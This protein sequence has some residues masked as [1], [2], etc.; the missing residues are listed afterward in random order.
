MSVDTRREEQ[1]IRRTT[2]YLV[3]I[4]AGTHSAEQVES[5]MQA[6]HRRF[7]G[8]PVRDFVP[9]LAERMARR[10]LTAPD[11][12]AP[13]T[14]ATETVTPAQAAAPVAPAAAA[15]TS[16]PATASASTQA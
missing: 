6:A 10:E 12:P 15:A 16:A 2:D 11:D 8:L 13:A 3:Q 9:V 1:A 4:F 7:D 5:V 14:S